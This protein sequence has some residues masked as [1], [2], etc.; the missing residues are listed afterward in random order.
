MSY[1]IT[2]ATTQI[3]AVVVAVLA[4]GALVFGVK[5]AVKGWKWIGRAL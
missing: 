1:D 2:S 4:V 5:L 3:A